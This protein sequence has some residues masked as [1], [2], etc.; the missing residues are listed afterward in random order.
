MVAL[1]KFIIAALFSYSVLSIYNIFFY[2]KFEQLRVKYLAVAV[3]LGVL[4]IIVVHLTW[5]GFY[6]LVGLFST[7]WPAI[8]VSNNDYFGLLLGLLVFVHRHRGEN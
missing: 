3:I 4:S 2:K 6:Y 5:V 7:V 1:V 8:T